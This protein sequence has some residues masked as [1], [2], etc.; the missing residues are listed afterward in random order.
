MLHFS[1]GQNPIPWNFYPYE[2]YRPNRKR[3]VTGGSWNLYLFGWFLLFGQRFPT[4]WS[5]VLYPFSPIYAV[6]VEISGRWLLESLPISTDF[7]CLGRDFQ[8]ATMGISTYSSDFRH[9]GRDFWAVGLGFSTFL[10]DFRCLGRDFRPRA[11]RISTYSADFP[12]F[13]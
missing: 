1:V 11:A 8:P 7:R 2:K 10:A 4:G 5:G 6:W 13:G 12:P 3:Y 9:L